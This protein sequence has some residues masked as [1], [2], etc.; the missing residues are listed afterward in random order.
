MNL[1]LNKHLLQFTQSQL[2]KSI[3]LFNLAITTTVT[4]IISQF[5][6]MTARW[7]LL[8]KHGYYPIVVSGRAVTEW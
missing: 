7:L 1:I 2:K 5:T 4:Q 6:D 8:K 3:I